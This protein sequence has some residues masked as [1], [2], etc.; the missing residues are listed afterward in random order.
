M[1]LRSPGRIAIILVNYKGAGDTIECLESIRALEAP[2]SGL[3]AIVVENGSPDDSLNRLREWL[4]KGRVLSVTSHNQIAAEFEDLNST[5]RVLLVPSSTNNGFAA[6]CNIGLVHAYRD[7]SITHFWLLNNDTTV[8]RRSALELLAS[9]LTHS[10]RSISGST[11]LYYD[12]PDIV[13]AAAG[14][15]YLRCIGRSYHFFKRKRLA[16]IADAQSPR[17]DYIVGASM[18]FSRFVL[19]SVGYLP[20]RYFLYAE[21]TDWCTRARTHGISLD[22]ARGSFVF[23]KEG[24]ST[25]AEQRF[26]RLSDDAF[27]YVCRNNLLYIWDNARPFTVSVTAYTVLL[28][29][30]YAIKGDPAK[31]RVTYRALR[32]FWRFRNGTYRI[33]FQSVSTVPDE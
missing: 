33:T 12:N 16:E 3:V 21:E 18:F 14:A 31:L 24:R 25:G 5:L 23:H 11:L 19:D 29:I 8:D 28:A 26:K 30:Y 9:S 20:E 32:D 1:P 15:R 27:Y 10:D 13:Q 17:F 4:Q 7:P 22:W 6:G 2:Q